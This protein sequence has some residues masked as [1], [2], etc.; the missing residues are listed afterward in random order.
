LRQCHAFIERT[1][2]R[3]HHETVQRQATFLH[4]V[5]DGKPLPH[6][7]RV[8]LTRR[9]EQVDCVTAVVEQ[10]AQMGQ[11]P[12]QVRREI[13]KDGRCRGRDDAAQF[14]VGQVESPD[15]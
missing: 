5:H 1:Y 3:A 10:V 15:G 4:R 11:Q 9:A 13:G 8:G 2:A 12:L 6:A 7:E 14:H